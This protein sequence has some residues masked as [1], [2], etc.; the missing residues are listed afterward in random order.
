MA[1]PLMQMTG[2]RRTTRRCKNSQLHVVRREALRLDAKTNLNDK[3]KSKEYTPR[4]GDTV[5]K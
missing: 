4:S 3:A 2:R 1:K 5:Q